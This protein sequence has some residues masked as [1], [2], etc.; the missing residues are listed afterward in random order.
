MFKAMGRFAA[1]IAAVVRAITL[2]GYTKQFGDRT[3][4]GEGR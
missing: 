3:E 2:D 4:R 1:A